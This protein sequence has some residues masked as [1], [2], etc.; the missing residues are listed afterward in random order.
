MRIILWI[1]EGANQKALANKIHSKYKIDLIII[2][3][4]KTKTRLSFSK[5]VERMADQL[6]CSDLNNAW[7]SMLNKYEESYKN[8]PDTQLIYTNSI[9][10]EQVYTDTISLQPDLILVSGTSM[11][12]EKLLSVKPRLGIMNLHTGLSP[13]V[14]GGPNCTNWCLANDQFHLIGNTIMWIDKGIDSGNIIA[15]EVT[16]FTGKESLTD[17]HIKVMDH[18]HQLY[19]RVIDAISTGGNSNIPQNELAQGITYYTKDWNMKKKQKALVNY[20][21]FA[22]VVSSEEYKLAQSSLKTVSFTR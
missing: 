6:F 19:T 11:I 8:Y 5:I 1:G 20:K 7:F 18:A 10:N 22:S 12:R 13:Y 3:S 15:T 2:E 17:I 16:K 14:K 9:N 4:K 21:K